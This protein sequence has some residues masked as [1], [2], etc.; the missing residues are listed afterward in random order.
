[1]TARNGG[2]SG[3]GAITSTPISDTGLQY[4][5]EM[6]DQMTSKIDA[7]G[8]KHKQEVTEL[9]NI[10]TN[11]LQHVSDLD[12]QV[13]ALRQQQQGSTSPSPIPP[14][15]LHYDRLLYEVPEE[16]VAQTE[17]LIGNA[18]W[19]THPGAVIRYNVVPCRPCRHRM[20]PLLPQRPPQVLTCKASSPGRVLATG[21]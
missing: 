6:E 19:T 16:K 5:K 3:S 11:L 14:K 20:A 17:E 21:L 10:I 18:L 12:Q 9:K 8:E 13:L 4:L 7:L 2:P 1:M 15:H